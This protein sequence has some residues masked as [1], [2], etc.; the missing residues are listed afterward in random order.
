MRQTNQGY[1]MESVLTQET[2]AAVTG[3][4]TMAMGFGVAG[5]VVI[6]KVLF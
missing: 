2:L 3:T 1:K 6:Y 5:I 4:I